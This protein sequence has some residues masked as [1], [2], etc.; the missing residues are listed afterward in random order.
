MSNDIAVLLAKDAIGQRLRDYCRGMDRIDD[1]LARALW[2]P[3]GEALYEGIF[4][5]TGEGF[6]E[7]VA[8][9]HRGLVVTSHEI[10]NV[11]IRVAG[12]VA[13]SETYVEVNLMRREGDK[14]IL[15][16]S[17][18][19]YLDRWSERGGRWAVDRR[20]YVRSFSIVREVDVVLGTSQPNRDDASY[21][22]NLDS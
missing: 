22:I 20:R 1:D 5:G 13:T 18:G 6:C 7:W 16:T 15:T 14:H 12:Q 11:S 10:F 8:E 21:D 9:F 3:G 4:E 17:H 19:R 2:H